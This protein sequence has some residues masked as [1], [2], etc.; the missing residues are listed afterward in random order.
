[1]RNAVHQMKNPFQPLFQISLPTCWDSLGKLIPAAEHQ[2]ALLAARMD[3]SKLSEM[4]G[5]LLGPTIF[6]RL[7]DDFRILHQFWN[8][9]EFMPP[10]SYTQRIELEILL[11]E[12]SD[13]EMLT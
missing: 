13:Y 7:S 11:K 6:Y 12:I 8:L 1:M 2:P 3:S 10:M 9:R 4:P 5:T